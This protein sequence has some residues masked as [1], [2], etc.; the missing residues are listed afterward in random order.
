MCI[1]EVAPFMIF[2][3]LWIFAFATMFY[4]LGS[5]SKVAHGFEGT[6]LALGYVFQTMQ[7]SFGNNSVPS[8]EFWKLKVKPENSFW[9]NLTTNPVDALVV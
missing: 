9:E 3:F 1:I 6:P 4:V 2:M 7:N 8:F 5:Y